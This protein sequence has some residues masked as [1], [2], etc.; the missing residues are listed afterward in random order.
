MK[1][2]FRI[3][4]YSEIVQTEILFQLQNYVIIYCGIF[5]FLDKLIFYCLSVRIDW[6]VFLN[7]QELQCIDLLFD[8]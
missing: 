7:G 3:L 2:F 6:N 1:S 5:Q 4:V 8:C